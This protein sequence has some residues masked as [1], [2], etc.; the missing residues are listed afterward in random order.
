MR[1]SNYCGKCGA[2]KQ[3]RAD[4]SSRCR[5]C[6][7]NWNRQYYHRSA[8]RRN[9]QRSLY[10]KRTYGVSV[11]YLEEL[12][13][14][15]NERCAICGRHWTACATARHYEY[16]TMFLQHLYVDH[17]HE[18]GKVRGLLCNKCNSA[19]AFLGE[20]L[21]LLDPLEGYLRKH[22]RVD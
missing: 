22:K 10:I 1:K 8:K 19:I 21:A 7:T 4:G 13:A 2:L 14:F 18:T 5:G 3:I 9:L 20:N 11:A 6:V 16:E 15:Q 17:D 12:L